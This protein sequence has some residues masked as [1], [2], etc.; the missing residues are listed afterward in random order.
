VSGKGID[1]SMR[2]EGFDDLRE[3][4]K[5]VAPSQARSILR[6]AVQGVAAKARD[7]IKERVPVDQ[8]DLKKS[9]RAIRKRATPDHPVSEVRGGFPMIMLEFGTSKM[10]A[11]PSVVPVAEQIRPKLA[12]IYR[13]EFGKKLEKSLARKRKK[14][15]G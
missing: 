12:A 2:I 4:L 7:M 15:G 8:G 9:I 13:E 3:T 14:E 5:E 6:Q 10:D 1:V 11:Q